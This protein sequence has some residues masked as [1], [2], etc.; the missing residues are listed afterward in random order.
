MFEAERVH[1]PSVLTGLDNVFVSGFAFPSMGQDVHAMIMY[2]RSQEKA[3]NEGQLRGPTRAG[4][5]T[6]RER[7]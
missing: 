7:R 2:T 6:L 4:K 1:V 3:A 5:H